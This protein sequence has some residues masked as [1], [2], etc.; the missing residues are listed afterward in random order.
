M[1]SKYE[2]DRKKATQKN[3]KQFMP[4]IHWPSDSDH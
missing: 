1:E 2:A 3:W 4:K